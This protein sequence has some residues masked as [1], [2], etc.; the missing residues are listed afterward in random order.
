MSEPATFVIDSADVPKLRSALLKLASVGYS[1]SSVKKRLGLEDIADVQWR[2]A[3]M[4]RSERLAG[5][6]PLALAIEMFLLQGTLPTDEVERLFTVSERE[7][8]VR[9]GL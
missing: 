2:H 4:Y 8:F 1:E 7:V 3:P 9:A 5:R 6:D